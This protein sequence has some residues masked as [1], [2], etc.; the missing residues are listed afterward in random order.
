MTKP[1]GIPACP[2]PGDGRG[3][4]RRPALAQDQNPPEPLGPTPPAL[5]PRQQCYLA[6]A[7]LLYVLMRTSLRAQTHGLADGPQ[8]GRPSL[9]GYKQPDFD[10][11]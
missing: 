10:V 5:R 1:R 3:G 11:R 2:S 8:G 9:E 6:E 7:A 4:R